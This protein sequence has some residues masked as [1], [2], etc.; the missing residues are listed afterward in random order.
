MPEVKQ[1]LKNEDIPRN[2]NQKDVC[3]TEIP[4][5]KKETVESNVQS[6]KPFNLFPPKGIFANL[7]FDELFNSPDNNTTN[8]NKISSKNE[9]DNSNKQYG[10]LLPEQNNIQLTSI[11]LKNIKSDSSD[12]EWVEKT[13]LSTKK[14]T[15]HKKKHSKNKKSKHKKKSKK[16]S[17]KHK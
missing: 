9:T 3:S 17:H 12:D 10:P 4:S 15:S 11:N 1:S 16:K 13:D 14:E 2:S 7:N 5:V 8:K 6:A